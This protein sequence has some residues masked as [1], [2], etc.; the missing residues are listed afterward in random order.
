LR[1]FQCARAGNLLQR[2]LTLLL[3]KMHPRTH[4]EL[5]QL[6]SLNGLNL[7][8][9]REALIGAS[10]E[11]YTLRALVARPGARIFFPTPIE[12]MRHATDLFW[13]EGGHRFAVSVKTQ[14]S[15]DAHVAVRCVIKAPNGGTKSW[16]HSHLDAIWHGCQ[17]HSTS[18]GRRFT[19]VA[20]QVSIRNRRPARLDRRWQDVKWPKNALEHADRH[21]A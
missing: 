7:T 21:A 15:H 19:A 6:G 8:R 12:D 16:P 11:A 5:I 14:F 1:T 20:V 10:G 18:F 9:W 4:S 2:E 13:F 17:H 3:L